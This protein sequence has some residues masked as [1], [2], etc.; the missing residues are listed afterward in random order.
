MC[1]S[2]LQDK[3]LPPRDSVVTTL[4]RWCAESADVPCW[5]NVT[6]A[7]IGHCFQS[8]S[9][10]TSPRREDEDDSISYHSISLEDCV[11]MSEWDEEV[12]LRA[13]TISR[14]LIPTHYA[15]NRLAA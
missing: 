15:Q 8:S 4:Y 5:A 7:S 3:A 14:L 10:T 1:R 9:A 2:P 12:R 6:T 11:A 13:L